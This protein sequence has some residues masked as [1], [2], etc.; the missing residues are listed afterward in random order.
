MNILYQNDKLWNTEKIEQERCTTDTR[1]EKCMNKETE[2]N[3]E[4]NVA[5]FWTTQKESVV[6]FF[7]K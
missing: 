7:K 3:K 6:L 1:A 4:K 2:R 5:F